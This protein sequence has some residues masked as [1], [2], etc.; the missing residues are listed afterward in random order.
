M[1]QS[2]RYHAVV[3]ERGCSAGGICDASIRPKVDRM[4]STHVG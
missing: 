3:R 1:K 2:K 4:H